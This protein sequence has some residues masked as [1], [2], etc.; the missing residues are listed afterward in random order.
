MLADI[1]I[2]RKLSLLLILPMAAFFY[3]VTTECAHRWG[4]ISEHKFIERS[5][6]VSISAGELIHEIQKERGYTAGF[7]GSK[8]ARY[9]SELSEQIRKTE[10]AAHNFNETLLK[11]SAS[12][13][14]LLKQ[15]FSPF[16][17]K[18]SELSNI[19]NAAKD[20]KID[21]FQ[22]I[23]TYNSCINALMT[24]I[25]DLNEHAGIFFTSILQLLHGK[26]VAG[27]ERAT[28]NAAFSAGT[29]SKQLYR[30]WLYRVSAQNTYLQSFIELGGAQA[31]NIFQDKM[32]S[33]DSEVN[34]FRDAAYEN[35]EKNSLN[36]DAHEWF[37]ASTKRIDKLMEVESAWGARLLDKARI[38]LNSAERSVLIACVGAILVACISIILGWRICITIGR[39]VRRTLSYAQSIT[40]GDFDAVLA[41]DQKDE[42]GSLAGELRIMVGRLKEHIHTAQKQHAIA[43][44]R[45]QV[46]EQCRITAE[47]A[48]KDARSRADT[49]SLAVKKIHGVVENA[50]TAL[51]NLSEQV[52]ISAEGA[53]TQASRLEDTTAAMQEMSITVV[54]VAKNAADA[55]QTAETSHGQATEG[56][57]VVDNVVSAIMQVQ[58]QSNEMKIDMGLLGQQAEGI[59]QI[60]N[61]IS[62]IAD[63]TNLLAL[64]AA[65]EAARAGDAGRGFAVV[66]D[67][68][69]K[70]AEKTMSATKEVGEAIQGIQSGTR[71]HIAHVEQTA[72]TIERVTVLAR[73]SGESL[74]E[75][76][77]LSSDTTSQVQSIATA[78][79][80]Q[81]VA[82]ETIQERLEDINQISIAT[83]NAMEMA[84]V[85]LKE[86][87]AQ[88]DILVGV[89]ADLNNEG[90]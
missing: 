28:L 1:K 65:I 18:V 10:A 88:T 3:I 59:G 66:A 60:L 85:A 9:T 52:R 30:D 58:T 34:R 5:L 53:Q 33:A 17:S 74:Q 81:S 71:K 43:E 83:A 75:L 32:K 19:R 62:D 51:K 8:G 7:L 22:A 26:E 11:M 64:N 6:I 89:M 78:S 82:S 63:Q 54:E 42:L 50:N 41:V 45:G 87:R 24:A 90:H 13:G 68:V 39:P 79:E 55:A 76:V 56:S 67:E 47:I 21:V 49:L 44:E 38:E 27:Q 20:Q 16:G 31:K 70:L 86:L 77:N 14:V 37:A 4:A 46:A 72:G 25:A 57:S 80:E 29:F 84:V 15:L 40:Q 2:A 61:V 36:T 69:R 73:Q 23:S 35:L 12:D 48:E